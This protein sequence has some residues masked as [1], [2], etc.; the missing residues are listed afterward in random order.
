MEA[1]TNGLHALGLTPSLAPDGR[2]VARVLHVENDKYVFR[3]IKGVMSLY[4]FAAIHNVH[5]PDLSNAARVLGSTRHFDLIITDHSP[6]TVDGAEVIR[7]ARSLPHREDTP[8][9]MFAS[10]LAGFPPLAAAGADAF[11]AKPPDLQEFK[12]TVEW[13]LR[14]AYS[15]T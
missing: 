10:A 6:A 7:V 15:L 3:A 12:E 8:V 14:S 13:L 1:R 11:L 9:L 5:C 2:R 4:E